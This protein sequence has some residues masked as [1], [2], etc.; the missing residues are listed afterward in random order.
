[1]D[2]IEAQIQAQLNAIQNQQGFSEYTP[3]FEQSLQPQGIAPLVES[4]MNSFVGGP[5]TIDPKEIGANI[6]KNQG[7]K[8]VARKLGL[9]KVGQNVL[10]SIAGITTLPFAPLTAVTALSGASSGIANVLRNKRVEKAIMR[11]I[12]RDSQGDIKIYDQKIKNMKPTAQDIY[13]GG[14][15]YS[16]PARSRSRDTSSSSSY[17]QASYARRT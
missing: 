7:V 9:G 6:L 15:G 8:L 14:G 1:M 5:T 3:S 13:R 2:P 12:N 17:S 16:G 11:D 4:P 10:G